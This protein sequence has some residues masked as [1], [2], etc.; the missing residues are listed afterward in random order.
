MKSIINALSSI[1]LSCILVILLAILTWLGTLEQVEYGLY[2]VQNK[3]FNSFILWHDFG[4]F[5][6]PLPGA[7]LV[8][9][10]L[11]VNLVLG[12][13][14]RIRKG[15]RNIGVL[16][17]HVGI[18]LLL[19]SGFVKLYHSYDGHV[20][21]YEGQSSS[22]F[23]SYFRYELAITTEDG[24]GGLREYVI[25]QE[26]WIDALGDDK[27]T[28]SSNELPFDL[29]LSH[30]LVNCEPMPKGPMF[31]VEVPVVDGFFLR[32]RPIDPEA[33]RNLGGLYAAAVAQGGERQ[34]GIL[35]SIMDA[36]WTV[37]AGGKRYAIDLRKE[38]Y[39]MPFTIV[40]NDF[41]KEDHPGI[42]MAKAFKSDVTVIEDGS[43]REVRI[44]MNEPLRDGG[45]VLYQ[46]SWGPANAS[47]GTPL[48]S[49]L[50]VVRNPSDQWP[51]WASYIVGIGMLIQFGMKLFRHMRSEQKQQLKASQA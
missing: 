30:F 9:C 14:V 5:A 27:V 31:E 8:M 43:A 18:L 6:V 26:E 51:K 3:Y 15:V 48:F 37:D 10:V 32:N 1:G 29:E 41:I 28:L 34:R 49:T 11:F 7:N 13:I 46:A 36:P 45:L 50:S 21:L 2:E 40:L 4:P 39:R 25:P 12:G 47:P 24:T 19:L 16:I 23:Q 22:E 17:T 38:R 20:T 33:E 35:W 42:T 44:Q